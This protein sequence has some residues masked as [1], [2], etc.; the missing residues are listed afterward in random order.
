[1]DGDGCDQSILHASAV[2]IL[3]KQFFPPKRLSF[4]LKTCTWFVDLLLN[5]RERGRV[6]S[7]L[8]TYF[9]NCFN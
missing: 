1:V 4:F 8:L 5:E 6:E 9:H 2:Q 3:G 7:F